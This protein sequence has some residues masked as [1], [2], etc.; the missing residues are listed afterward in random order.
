MNRLILL[1]CTDIPLYLPLPNNQIIKEMRV[2]SHEKKLRI[3][4][5]DDDRFFRE[6][7]NILIEGRNDFEISGSFENADNV[8]DDINKCNPDV[9]LMDI[10]MP[11][12]N[13][14]DAVRILKSRYPKLP[15]MMLTV[16]NKEDM[17]VDSI[18]AGADGYM[19]KTTSSDK[20]ID[21]I[22]D[23]FNGYGA[24]CA[25]VAKQVL[26]LFAERFSSSKNKNSYALSP[27][28]RQVLLHLVKGKSTKMISA[29]M[30]IAYNTVR[31]HIKHIYKKLQVSSAPAAVAK[32]LKQNIIVS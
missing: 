32:A 2:V 27:R 3:A 13:G 17:V 24:L 26:S 19:L 14:I 8:L 9:V 5:F 15:V 6:T 31:V 29:D 16:H 21:N 10:D 7:A 25:P 23:V 11:G 20:I 30:D 22:L 1:L 12:T 28:E 4:V 18:C